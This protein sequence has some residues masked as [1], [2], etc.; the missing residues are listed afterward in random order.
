MGR[1][2][3]DFERAY[4]NDLADEIIRLSGDFCILHSVD[5][6][7]S[8]G[9]DEVSILYGESSK[10]EDWKTTP[11]EGIPAL[12]QN[13]MN[14]QMPDENG[15]QFSKSASVQIA[16]KFLLANNIPAPKRGDIVFNASFGYWDIDDITRSGFYADDDDCF[17]F[18]DI[19]LVY[20][21]KFV[22]ALRVNP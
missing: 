13:L 4:R 12:F 3:T 14:D 21:G 2:V 17:T 20:N 11:Y 16:R 10:S 7:E 22:P 19:E 18:Y 1:L 5:I 6:Q 8:I 15:A 9:A